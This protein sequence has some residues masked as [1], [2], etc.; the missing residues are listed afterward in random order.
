MQTG[1][2]T[3]ADLIILNN[4]LPE[5][6]SAHDLANTIVTIINEPSSATRSGYQMPVN[7]SP[8][9]QTYCNGQLS[10]ESECVIDSSDDDSDDTLSTG[11]I[12][13][14]AIGGAV[15]LILL[16]AICAFCI[17]RRSK[18]SSSTT[19][20]TSSPYANKAR[21]TSRDPTTTGFHD[22]NEN[23]MVNVHV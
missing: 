12:V 21:N 2:S 8:T 14:I 11:A 18:Y 9:I 1:S 23:E 10:S 22:G 4:D 17:R 13:G 16:I 6:T 15:A 19:Y 3:N 7:Q 20:N 5:G